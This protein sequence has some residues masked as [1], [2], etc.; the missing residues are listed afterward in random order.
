M[1][2]IE[3]NSKTDHSGHIKFDYQ[4][5]RSDQNVRILILLEEDNYQLEEEKLWIDSL[6]NNPA[7]NFLREPEENVYS[8]KDGESLND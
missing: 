7:F 6:S 4:L 5:G 8:L 1:R 3:I 2:A